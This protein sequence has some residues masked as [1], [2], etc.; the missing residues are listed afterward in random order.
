MIVYYHSLLAKWKKTGYEKLCCL[1]C[2]Q[3]RVWRPSYM[4]FNSQTYFLDQKDM[5]YQGS[6][7]ICRVPKTQVRAGTVVECVHCGTVC[8]RL[9]PSLIQINVI[10]R[11]PRMQFRFII[12]GFSIDVSLV[13]SKFFHSQQQQFHTRRD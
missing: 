2:I 7:C 10:H 11:L 8:L 12:S 3:T 6:T 1:R 9:Y 5:N 4:I 13:Y